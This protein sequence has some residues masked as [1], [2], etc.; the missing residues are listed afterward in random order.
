MVNSE[1]AIK[2]IAKVTGFDSVH[3]FTRVFTNKIGVP[4]AMFRKSQFS[5]NLIPERFS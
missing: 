1:I 5:D 2:E 4:P 3:Y